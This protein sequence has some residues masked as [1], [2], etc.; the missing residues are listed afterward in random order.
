[1]AGTL[2]QFRTEEHTKLQAIS[3]CAQLGI[4]L[5]TYL[6]MCMTRLVQENGV[7]F[8]MK[9][10]SAAENPGISAMREASRAAAEYG[11]ADMTL[12]EINAEI[13]K[14]RSGSGE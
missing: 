13:A 8:S 14:V 10:D 3:I 7:P 2:V 9:L 6:R 12:E 4:D 11:I 1:M 5:P